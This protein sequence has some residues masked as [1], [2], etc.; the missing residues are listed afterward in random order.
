MLKLYSDRH[1][2]GNFHKIW[3]EYYCLDQN[4]ASGI[5]NPKLIRC[6]NPYQLRNLK[7][8][9]TFHGLKNPYG[10]NFRY[11]IFLS[12]KTRRYRYYQN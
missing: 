9:S 4:H 5:I 3:M 11:L 2:R 8:L 10:Q 12:K 7:I 1:E 6:Q